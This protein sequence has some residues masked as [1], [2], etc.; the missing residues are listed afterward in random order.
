M[1]FRIVQLHFEALHL[2]LHQL[3][4]QKLFVLPHLVSLN[5]QVTYHLLLLS[6][7]LHYFEAIALVLAQVM[8]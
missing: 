1:G 7:V 4:S 3:L 5:C 2:K 6:D 8:L